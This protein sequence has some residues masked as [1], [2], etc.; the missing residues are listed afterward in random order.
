MSLPSPAYFTTHLTRVEEQVRSGQ[1]QLPVLQAPPAA[2]GGVVNPQQLLQQQLMLQQQLLQQ[3]QQMLLAAGGGVV[4]PSAIVLPAAGGAAAG[5]GS[6]QAG[7]IGAP[8]L[9]HSRGYCL[10]RPSSEPLLLVRPKHKAMCCGAL[11]IAGLGGPAGFPQQGPG[12]LGLPRGPG[13]GPGP[14]QGGPGPSG[15]APGSAPRHFG[16]EQAE[17]G[18]R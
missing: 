17:W 9:Y 14:A 2:V 4:A 13:G 16:V 11:C 5:G 3:Q 15:G 1:L 6:G 7:G 10:R 8:S 12:G 18:V